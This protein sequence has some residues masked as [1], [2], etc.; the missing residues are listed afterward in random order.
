MPVA[1]LSQKDPLEPA[2]TGLDSAVKGQSSQHLT[3]QAYCLSVTEQPDVNLS[4]FP[5][6]DPIGKEINAG[7]VKARKNSDLYLNKIS[8]EIIT[9]IGNIQNY[10]QLHQ[11]IPTALDAGSSKEEWVDSL[12]ALK[13]QAVEFQGTASNTRDDIEKLRDALSGDVRSFTKVVNDLNVAVGGD[14]GVLND[15]SKQLDTLQSKI[16]GAISGIVLSGLAILGGVFMTLVGA[17]A[18]FVTGGAATALVVGG[19]AIICAGVGGEV[20]SSLVLQGALNAKGDLLR[21]EA[22]LKEEVKLATGMSTAYNSLAQQAQAAAQAA[23]EMQNAWD[24]L[25]GHLGS[26]AEDIN[27]GILA[28]DAVRKLWLT[29]ANGILVKVNNDIDIIQGQMTGAQSVQAPKGTNIGEFVVERAKK[30]AA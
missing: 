14:N 6:L 3:I 15:I 19:I 23:L 27:K 2:L 11:S 30:M 12:K 7:L 18:E 9:N 25:G 21:K 13:D 4:A 1:T 10:Y 20:A 17:F 22:S 28:K 26:L 5:R 29:T 16:D 24:F 8:K